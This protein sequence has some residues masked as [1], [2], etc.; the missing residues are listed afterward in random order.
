MIAVLLMMLHIALSAKDKVGW[1][2]GGMRWCVGGAGGGVVRVWI[3][4]ERRVARLSQQRN[5][6]QC[7]VNA[8]CVGNGATM[9]ATIG[10]RY[11]GLAE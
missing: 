11:E 1:H 4:K 3:H 7:C 8:W 10:G 5:G 9:V 2:H 6:R